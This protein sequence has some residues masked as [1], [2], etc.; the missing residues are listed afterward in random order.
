MTVTKYTMVELDPIKELDEIMV[1][2]KDSLNTDKET[3]FKRLKSTGPYMV[4]VKAEG[5]DASVD[6]LI[7]KEQ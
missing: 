6:D 7:E 2:L 1:F 4:F 5:I 3:R